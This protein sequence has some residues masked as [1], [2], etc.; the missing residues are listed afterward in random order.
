MF[1]NWASTSHWSGSRTPLASAMP[2]MTVVPVRVFTSPLGRRVLP[3]TPSVTCSPKPPRSL[4]P[5]ASSGMS[6][7]SSLLSLALRFSI[8]ASKSPMVTF[9]RSR[10]PSAVMGIVAALIAT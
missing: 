10:P 2:L 7:S 4:R 6:M 3:F 8:T 1:L 9:A 5:I